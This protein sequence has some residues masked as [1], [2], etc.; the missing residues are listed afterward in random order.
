MPVT[1]PNSEIRSAMYDVFSAV[2][3]AVSVI[4]RLRIGLSTG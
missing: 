3:S 4:Q 1:I 2:P